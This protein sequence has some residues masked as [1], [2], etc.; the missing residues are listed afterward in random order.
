V[1]EGFSFPRTPVLSG[2]RC[3]PL[4]GPRSVSFPALAVVVNCF[5]FVT[6]YRRRSFSTR[7]ARALRGRRLPC[8]CRHSAAAVLLVLSMQHL[9]PVDLLSPAVDPGGLMRF[10]NGAVRRLGPDAGP[11]GVPD[12]PACRATTM[13]GQLRRRPSCRFFA[14][15][16]PCIPVTDFGFAPA[17][18]RLDRAAR[19]AARAA[20]HIMRAAVL[21]AASGLP[22]AA[23]QGGAEGME[24]N[25]ARYRKSAS[26]NGVHR[27]AQADSIPAGSS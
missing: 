10:R 7:R 13:P 5:R 8:L 23:A 15:S 22:C 16:H 12:S 27:A 20:S 17:A 1:P 11:P 25:T 26:S 21:A 6:A 14:H 9:D 2:V 4:F 19:R 3:S 18:C 24:R